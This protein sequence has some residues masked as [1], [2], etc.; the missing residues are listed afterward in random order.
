MRGD[1]LFPLQGI[2]PT[3]RT[4]CP[5]RRQLLKS[6]TAAALL[7]ACGGRDVG[8][9][10]EG[11]TPVRSAEPARWSPDGNEDTGRFPWGV[12]S[13]DAT[14][15]SA[16]L[17]VHTTEDSVSIE[18]VRGEGTEWVEE[19][20]L[21][22]L[23]VESGLVQ[24][25]I[26]SL[27]SDTVYNGVAWSADG[28]QRSEVF[29]FRTA[30]AVEDWRVVTFGTT[31]C[32]GYSNLGWECL[33]R[34]G[35]DDLDFFCLLG[36]TV[37]A[38]GSTTLENYRDEYHWVMHQDSI[39]KLT[40]STSL[41]ATWDDHEVENNWWDADLPDEQ[42][43]AAAQAFQEALP[44]TTGPTGAFWRKLSWGEVLDV[45]VLDTRGE[46]DFETLTFLSDAQWSWLETELK[47]SQARFKFVL[48]GVPIADLVYLYASTS[49][50]DK[51]VGYPDERQRLL[52]FIEDNALEGVAIIAGDVHHGCICYASAAG[53]IGGSVLEVITG[54]AGSGLNP[55]ASLYSEDEQHLRWIYDWTYTRFTADP[56]TGLVWIE[57]VNNE[58]STVADIE[59]EL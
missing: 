42:I 13:G 9:T 16:L 30:C 5:T 35:E 38:D 4:M 46:R 18:I 40:L 25:E 19:Q 29:R 53:E 23:S 28:T 14:S 54:P 36:D 6:M 37:Y 56:G 51:W 55:F 39:R 32:L 3:E 21:T 20:T 10:G 26:S 58:G 2:P 47:D 17:S 33:S 8:E 41:I 52:G 34:A 15:S 59:V 22:G 27:E 7:P 44:Q 50:Y 48:S 49:V 43:E 45:F 12:Q 24:V 1:P 31:S 11:A 57:F